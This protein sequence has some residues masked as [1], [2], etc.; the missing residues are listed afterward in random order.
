MPDDYRI[1]GT[2]LDELDDEDF[3]AHVR[4]ALG[5]FCR[6]EVADDDWEAVQRAAQLRPVARPMRWPPASR[7]RR[8]RSASERAP[9]ALPVGAAV[10]RGPDRAHARR[11]RAGRARPR[12]DG[13]AVRHRPG[14][15]PRAQRHRPRG[16]RRG[17]DLQ[18]RPLPRQGSGAEHAGPAVRQRL[19]R[20]A[21]EPRAHRPRADRRARDAVD[22]HARRVLRGH[23][24]VPRH[25]RHAPAAGAR[26]G[27]DGAAA[28]ARAARARGREDQGLPL[29]CCRSSP[30]TWC[31]G[32]TRATATSR[33]SRRTRT[34][35]RSSPRG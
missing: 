28:V 19:P 13:E 20:A 31:A 35:R 27:G 10:R 30:T 17:P 4:D 34:S 12:G 18:D 32:S 9:S 3:R 1:V 14:L 24:R 29:R 5:E 33:A 2:S 16:L 6:M 26:R 15:G 23:G 8:R 22:R 7:A 25:D 11:G 21:V